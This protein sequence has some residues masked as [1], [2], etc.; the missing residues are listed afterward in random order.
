MK[1]LQWLRGCVSTDTVIDEYQNLQ[2]YNARSRACNSC[3]KQSMRCDHRESILNKIT[4]LKRRR[5]LKPLILS[6][7]LQFFLQFSAIMTWR[8]YII[9]ILNAYA[10]RWNSSYFAVVMSSMGLVAKICAMSLVKMMGKR[11][12][13]L[14]ASTATYLSCFG[15]S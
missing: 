14:V 4:Q 9:Q 7:A 10:I 6:I 13:Y 3:G 8:P 15:L 11:K 12:L 5:I 1:S 2:R